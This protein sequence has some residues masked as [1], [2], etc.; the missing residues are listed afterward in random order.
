MIRDRLPA[1][2]PGFLLECQKGMVSHRHEVLGSSAR[3]LADSLIWK[4]IF[5]IFSEGH[6]ISFIDRPVLVAKKED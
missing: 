1:L 6:L 4:Q 2:T 3:D 5:F